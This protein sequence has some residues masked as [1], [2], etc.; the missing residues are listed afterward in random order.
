MGRK[1]RTGRGSAAGQMERKKRM[2]LKRAREADREELNAL[3]RETTER[4]EADGLTQWHWGEYPSEEM[5]AEAISAGQM[6]LRREAGEIVAAV[7]IDMQM[8]EAYRDV[9]WSWGTQPGQFRA[10][11]VRPDQQSTGLGA[12]VLDD[13][14]KILRE[15]G[16][17]SVRCNTD[18]ENRRAVRLYEKLGFRRCGGV[19]DWNER[20]RGYLPFDKALMRETPLLPVRMKPAFRSGKLTPWGGEKLQTLF[21]KAIPEVPTGES[22]EVSCIPGLES[23]D[24][25]GRKLP[26]LMTEFG[27]KMAGK[28]TDRPFPLLLKLI[29]A[30]EALSVQVHPDDDYAAREEGGKLGKTEAWLILD[31]PEGAE[32]VYGIRPGTELK[33]L[34][35]ACEAGSAVAPLLNRVKVKAGDV[36]YI[37]AGCVHAIGAGIT[38]YEIQQ[39]SDI[40]YR[41]YDWDRVDKQGNRRELHIRRALDVTDLTLRPEPIHAPETI[42]VRR[43]LNE[44]YFTLDVIRCMKEEWLPAIHDF[45]LLTVLEGCLELRWKNGAMRMRRGDSCFLPAA[46]PDVCL[47]GLGCA[48]LSM[49]AERIRKEDAE[50]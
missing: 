16:C 32:L 49:P 42:G 1:N 4:M 18:P 8:D 50:A 9:D 10:L 20:Q 11:A 38:L 19:I 21:H 31:A 39:S 2:E 45:G 25:M 47:A 17:D 12:I 40:T 36:C 37:P 41:F 35:Q 33:T 48:A 23:T 44:E 15:S 14:M 22:L 46:A 5:I 13:V 7:V 6:Y 26:E 28:Y 3:Y 30:R 27:A 29:D 43:V 24:R 34:E